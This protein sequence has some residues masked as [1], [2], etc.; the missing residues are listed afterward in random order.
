MTILRADGNLPGIKT[1]GDCTMA[2]PEKV[3]DGEA[4]PLRLRW[5][6]TWSDHDADYVA[7]ADGYN[8]GVG[9]IYLYDSGPQ[10]G[11]W[12]WSMTA[13]GFEISRNIGN[14]SG[15]ERS[16]RAAAR[17]VEDAW[18]VAIKGSSLDRP[19]PA[20]NAYAAAKAGE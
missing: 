8:G 1:D 19:P 2:E 6:Q 16:A 12:F 5:R 18:F 4:L 7:N 9:R 3:A 17:M 14:L 20:R 10:K 11:M 13:H 15:A